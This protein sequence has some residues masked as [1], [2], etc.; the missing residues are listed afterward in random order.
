M[1]SRR[2]AIRHAPSPTS[3]RLAFTDSSILASPLTNAPSFTNPSSTRRFRSRK[4]TSIRASSSNCELEEDQCTSLTAEFAALVAQRYRTHTAW[5]VHR[6]D[7]RADARNQHGH[8]VVP[9]R[10][11]VNGV[12]ER[13]L[14]ILDDHK[15][16]RV[17]VAEIRKLWERTA[18]THLARAG[19]TARVDV[20]RRED[21]NPVPTLG[22]GCTAIEREAA[23]EGV[24]GAM[25][26]KVRLATAVSGVSERPE[27]APSDRFR[28]GERVASQQVD[29]LVAER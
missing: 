5:S 9:T 18:N 10:E 25:E 8:I 26:R 13:K 12:F 7:K 22:R 27:L 17:E 3:W 1:S 11:L 14:R 16:G 6:P 29:V 23:V 19:H 20:S 28:Y 24:W 21:D 4:A 15:T 2:R